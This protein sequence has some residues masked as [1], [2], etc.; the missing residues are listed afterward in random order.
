MSEDD[1]GLVQWVSSHFTKLFGYRRDEVAGKKVNM[2]MPPSYAQRHDTW[3][4]NWKEKGTE[5]N[6][7]KI[8]RFWIVDKNGHC[9]SSHSFIKIVPMLTHFELVGLIRKNNELDYILLNGSSGV[10][11][12][13]GKRLAD[14]I[15]SVDPQTLLHANI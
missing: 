4:R 2:L 11:E 6:M 14:N 8:R 10:I 15:L 12:S 3:M 9:C 1:L 5:F 13:T 7:N